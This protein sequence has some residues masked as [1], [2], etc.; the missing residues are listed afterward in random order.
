MRLLLLVP[1]KLF[2]VLF[3][4]SIITNTPLITKPS[5]E[6]R[7]GVQEIC[8]SYTYLSNFVVLRPIIL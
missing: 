3:P 2:A 1:L 7:L 4:P 5:S 6:I 8:G